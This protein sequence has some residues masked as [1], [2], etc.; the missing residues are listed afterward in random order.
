M[1]PLKKTLTKGKSCFK[2]VISSR[3][4]SYRQYE[5]RPDTFFGFHESCQSFICHGPLITSIV[6]HRSSNHIKEILFC[7]ILHE[8]RIGKAN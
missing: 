1:Y 8:I 6:E 2:H 4:E 5:H 7:L 3:E